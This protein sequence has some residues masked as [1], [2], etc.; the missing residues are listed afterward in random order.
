MLDR[1][2]QRPP[3]KV[4]SVMQVDPHIK[5]PLIKMEGQEVTDEA[6]PISIQAINNNIYKSR[7][8]L[9]EIDL[10]KSLNKKESLKD[11]KNDVDNDDYFVNYY[12]RSFAN[13]HNSGSKT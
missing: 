9:P 2:T 11:I 12:K 10:T 5:F 3:Y 1:W 8:K 7:I 6:N 4:R 13:L